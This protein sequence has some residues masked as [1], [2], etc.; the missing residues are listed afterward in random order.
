MEFAQAHLRI[1]VIQRDVELDSLQRAKVHLVHVLTHQLSPIEHQTGV[2]NFGGGCGNETEGVLVRVL[3]EGLVVH[4]AGHVHLPVVLQ[5]GNFEGAG[6]VCLD[7]P[8]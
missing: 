4:A 5:L 2:V 6:T 3:R 8:R 1:A 7:A